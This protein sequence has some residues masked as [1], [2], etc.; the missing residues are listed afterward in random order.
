[1]PVAGADGGST[2]IHER[3]SEIPAGEL[4]Q[5]QQFEYLSPTNQR[6]ACYGHHASTR[7]TV[8]ALAVPKASMIRGTSGRRSSMRL[9]AAIRTIT[10]MSK[11]ERFCWCERLRSL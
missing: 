7:V 9:L 8:P 11:A 1:M 4:A 10:A 6:C 3:A 2:P 5:V